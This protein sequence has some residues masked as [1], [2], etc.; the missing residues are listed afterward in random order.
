[1]QSPETG[2]FDLG[3]SVIVPAYD[4]AGNLDSLIEAVLANLPTAAGQFEIVLVDD[5]STDETGAIA[6][7]L[8][9]RHPA[10]RVIHHPHN[11]GFGAAVRSGI[12]AARLEWVVVIPADHQFDIR[13]LPKLLAACAGAD[14]VCAY[15]L[16]RRDTRRRRAVSRAYNWYVARVHGYHFRDLNWVKMFRRA[17][18]ERITIESSGFCIDIEILLKARVL[19]CRVVEV[20][21]PHHPRQWGKPTAISVGNV[22]RTVRELA[23]IRAWVDATLP[24]AS[25]HA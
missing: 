23:R 11:L 17:I 12:A 10:V 13:D 25:Q 2:A 5:G 7:A 22:Y 15:R 21:V 20:P 14:I 6:D 1:M 24:R 9:L 8:A 19:G 3:L 16:G 4:E 18:F